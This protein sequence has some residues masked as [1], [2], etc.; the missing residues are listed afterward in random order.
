VRFGRILNVFQNVAMAPRGKRL[1]ETQRRSDAT[2]PSLWEHDVE[3]RVDVIAMLF[4][5]RLLM[6]HVGVDVARL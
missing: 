1:H 2:L 6:L 4:R 5:R 3:Q